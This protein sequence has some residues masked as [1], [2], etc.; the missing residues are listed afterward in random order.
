[1][2]LRI[3]FVDDEPEFVRAHIN[4]LEDAGYSVK[5]TRSYTEALG[6]LQRQ[7]FDLIVLDLILPPID[8]YWELEYETAEPSAEVGLGLHRVIREELG[9]IQVPIVFFTVVGEIEAR[10]QIQETEAK[11]SLKP[12]VLIKPA[13][14]S[15]LLVQVRELVGGRDE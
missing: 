12:T 13:L 3:L 6:T 9:L 4:A 8:A 15:K 5:H 2:T 10:R 7:S 11:F 14:P 1:M